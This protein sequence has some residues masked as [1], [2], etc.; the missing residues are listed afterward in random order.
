MSCPRGKQTCFGVKQCVNT[1]I[2]VHT[3]APRSIG[4]THLRWRGAGN[5][6]HKSLP[7]LCKPQDIIGARVFFAFSNI[8][9]FLPIFLLA[10]PIVAR[11]L[12][13]CE[14]A[15][16][17]PCLEW[18]SNPQAERPQFANGACGVSAN[19]RSQGQRRSLERRSP[20]AGTADSSWHSCRPSQRFLVNQAFASPVFVPFLR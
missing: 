9:V 5:K 20:L 15:D 12:S 6:R 16:E 18:G 3:T 1:F 2:P 8:S 7:A 14:G 11:P 17:D 10:I 13:A 4:S 19:K